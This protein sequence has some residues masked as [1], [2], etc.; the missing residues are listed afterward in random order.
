MELQKTISSKQAELKVAAEAA[1][2][3]SAE[4]T[5]MQA[6]LKELQALRRVGGDIARLLSEANDLDSEV[7][8]LQSDLATTG[9]TQ[10]GEQVQAEIDQLAASIKVLKRELNA[11]QQDRE[12]KRT[13]I[14]SLE[15]DAHRAEVAVIT[16]KQEYAKKASIEA[17]L[18]ETTADL[19]EQQKR[20]KSL[21]AEIETAN[22]P[23]RR[24]KDE[25]EAFKAEA[26]E[27]EGKL[28]GRADKLEG[29]AKQIRELNARSTPTS[30]SEAI[31]VWKN[32]SRPSRISST[33]SKAFI[34]TSRS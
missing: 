6:E 29:W 17:Q 23:I 19:E 28:K 20:I 13:L 33:R 8:S 7:Q 12:T 25:L 3:S 16:K 2:A 18:Q 32:A 10:T 1:E 27:A 21:D 4:V 31:N 14:S 34:G 24:A 26:S 30:S 9:S 15:R 22:A 5:K 11:L